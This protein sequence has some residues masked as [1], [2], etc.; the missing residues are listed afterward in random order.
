MR[1]LSAWSAAA[2][3]YLGA[4]ETYTAAW[5][6]ARAVNGPGQTVRQ[7]LGIAGV[8]PAEVEA[9]L[10]L[11]ERRDVGLVKQLESDVRAITPADVPV[12]AA[13]RV[14][15]APNAD[16]GLLL[17]NEEEHERRLA[18]MKAADPR[19]RFGGMG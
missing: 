16:V 7:V 10:R 19:G 11:L 12:D 2:H 6:N 8:N 3:D 9:G 13:G 1:A 15:L 5:E 14:G 17:V 4:V 18:R